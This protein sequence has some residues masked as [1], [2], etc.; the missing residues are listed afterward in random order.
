MRIMLVGLLALAGF[1]NAQAAAW[2]IRSGPA[3]ATVAL[4][5]EKTRHLGVLANVELLFHR[6]YLSWGLGANHLTAGGY[7]Y[8]GGSLVLGYYSDKTN[9]KRANWHLLS[10]FGGG[11]FSQTPSGY[12]K[13][14]GGP[15]KA[16]FFG[17]NIG[18]NYLVEPPK[19]ES[20][21]SLALTFDL[22][23]GGA[24]EILFNSKGLQTRL[25][26]YHLSPIMGL[27]YNW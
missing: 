6:K 3:V 21:S 7:H 25:G 22:E 5:D 12:S 8:N 15:V 27:T 2:N 16:G 13:A 14:P 10:S 20:K 19:E 9:T 4:D 18:T 1:S 24:S 23:L 26:I 11:G 17:F